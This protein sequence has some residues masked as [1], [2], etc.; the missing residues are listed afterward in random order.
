MKYFS[1]EKINRAIRAIVESETTQE[2]VTS[3]AASELAQHYF[4]KAIYTI[5]PEQIQRYTSKRPDYVIEKFYPHN[6]VNFWFIPHAFI[7]VKSLVGKNISH[8]VNQ[9]HD[10]VFAAMDDWGNFTGHYSCFMIGIKGTKI[11]FYTYHNL[12]S[13]LD[14]YGIFNYKG[15]IPLNLRIPSKLFLQMNKEHPL[16]EALYERYIRN[17]NFDTNHDSLHQKGVTDISDIPFPH[18]FDLQDI[19]HREDIHNMFVYIASNTANYI[20]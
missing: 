1:V 16:K 4:D 15:L 10:T 11:A 3:R 19:R 12:S 6:T 2:H 18:I 7:E 20:T 13:L 17:I 14:E 8:I 9:L 5:V